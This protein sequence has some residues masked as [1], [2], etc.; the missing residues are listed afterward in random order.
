MVDLPALLDDL[1]AEAA[2]LDRRV[3]DLPTADWARPTPAAGW[4]I[5]HQIAHLAWTDSVATLAATD[6]DRFVAELA[7]AAADDPNGLVHRMAESSL[8][9]PAE[10]LHRWR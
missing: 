1:D 2:D 10:L 5:A 3:A 6:P 9:P 7:V 4:T 8:A